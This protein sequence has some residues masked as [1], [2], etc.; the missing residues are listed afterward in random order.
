MIRPPRLLKVLLA[1]IV[2]IPVGLTS[3]PASAD[4]VPEPEHPWRLD[5]WP[6]TQP[7]QQDAPEAGTARRADPVG[8]AA[9]DPRTGRTRTT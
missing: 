7:W 4:P 3:V 5:H 8:P 1:A 2:L 6:R 9:I